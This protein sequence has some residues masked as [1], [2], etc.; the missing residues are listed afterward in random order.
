MYILAYYDSESGFSVTPFKTMEE[1]YND[2]RS[3]LY[4]WYGDED[5]FY[6]PKFENLDSSHPYSSTDVYVRRYEDN[7]ITIDVNDMD[8]ETHAFI[9][10]IPNGV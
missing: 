7:S 9:Q 3:T 10:R 1:A 8:T 4:E 2:M 5:D 6:V